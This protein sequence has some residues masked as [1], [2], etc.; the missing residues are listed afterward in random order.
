MTTPS[1]I[2]KSNSNISI[3]TFLNLLKKKTNIS[4]LCDR[5]NITIEEIKKHF[6]NLF[7]LNGSF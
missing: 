7:F 4:K 6:V 5:Y 3:E 1:I 2:P